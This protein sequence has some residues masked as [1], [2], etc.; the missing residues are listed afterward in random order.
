[1]SVAGGGGAFLSYRRERGGD[2]VG[3]LADRLVD[4][5]RLQRVFIDVD[6]IEPRA[7]D[8]EQ[9]QPT[10]GDISAGLCRSYWPLSLHQVASEVIGLASWKDK[11][12]D[13]SS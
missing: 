12:F 1:M 6:A 11:R 4:H 13:E 9:R 3:R 10:S 8:S 5:F 7:S 2:A